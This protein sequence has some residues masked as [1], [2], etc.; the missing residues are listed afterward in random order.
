MS[1]DLLLLRE[2]ATTDATMTE[3]ATKLERDLDR[4]HGRRK[5]HGEEEEEM[6]AGDAVN[7]QA[8]EGG[9][10]VSPIRTRSCPEEVG[11]AA[12]A[13]KSSRATPEVRRRNQSNR[14]LNRVEPS[15][16]RPIR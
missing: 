9:A 10:V 8:K 13:V 7:S 1:G 12:E 5:Q 2:G 4:R 6:A 15:R 3:T 14:T 11:T 16:Q